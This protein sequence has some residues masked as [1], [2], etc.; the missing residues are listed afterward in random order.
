[1][2]GSKFLP[3]VTTS[4]ILGCN[5]HM[6]VEALRAA[7]KDTQRTRYGRAKQ[8][9]SARYY[10]E[11]GNNASGKLLIEQLFVNCCGWSIASVDRLVEANRLHDTALAL[12]ILFVSYISTPSTYQ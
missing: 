4:K 8:D 11:L 6:T 10:S 9:L 1:M 7:V 5:I 3:G 12:P 2:N